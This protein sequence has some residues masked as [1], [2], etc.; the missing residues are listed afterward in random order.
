MRTYSTKNYWDTVASEL[1]Q[2]TE[3]DDS[4]IASD[5]TPYYALKQTRFFEEFLD[6]AT[7]DARSVLEIGSGPGGNL[8]RISSHG[9]LA[10]GVDVSPS[11]LKLARRRGPYGLVQIDG[12]RL[13]FQDGSCDAVFTS[14]VLQHNTPELATGLLL[15]MARVSARE[16]H[17]FE[18]TAPLHFRDRRSHWLRPPSWYASR[19][20]PLGY[21]L[22]FQKRLPL[23]CQE[24]A[25]TVARLITD[26]GQRQGA[27]ATM[28]RLRIED[29]L[30][31]LARPVDRVIPPMMGLTRMSFYR[32]SVT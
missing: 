9:K 28:R 22:T 15:E 2:R 7:R 1:L 11:M 3:D 30:S 25:A 5:D 29:G 20:E 19:L 26:R 8:A 14:T 23:T 27:P 16:I 17:L 32:T 21:E 13:P 12:S 18:D 31:R 24:I 4:T 10:F 6:M